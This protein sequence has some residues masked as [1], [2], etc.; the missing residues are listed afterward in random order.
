[1]TAAV[2]HPPVR[3]FCFHVHYKGV[4]SPVIRIEGDTVCHNRGSHATVKRDGAIIA[5]VA[6]PGDA[7][8]VAWWIEEAATAG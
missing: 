3:T 1:M 2:Q 4:L 7:V 5:E 8:I 6:K